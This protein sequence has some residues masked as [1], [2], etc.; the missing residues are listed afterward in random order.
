V[1]LPTLT[2]QTA[3]G[4]REVGTLPNFAGPALPT[5]GINDLLLGLDY[6]LFI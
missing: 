4:S 1:G 6:I 3:A 2:L 5:L